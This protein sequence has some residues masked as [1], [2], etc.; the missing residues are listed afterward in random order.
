MSVLKHVT[1]EGLWDERRVETDF[2]PKV[3][4]L[5]GSNGSGKTTLLNLVASALSSD[6]DGLSRGHFSTIECDLVS[7]KS[8]AQTKVVVGRANKELIRPAFQYTIQGPGKKE[9]K[10]EIVS[11]SPRYLMGSPIRL[12]GRVSTKVYDAET[13]PLTEYVRVKWLTVHRAPTKARGEDRPTSD[14]SVDRHLGTLSNQL[15]RYFSKLAAQREEETNRFLREMLAS[16]IYNA[17]EFNPFTHAQGLDLATM[18]SS[19]E[20]LLDTFLRP[21]AAK[22]AR[23]RLKAHF[24]LAAEAQGNKEQ[25]K[26][27]ELIALATV[28]PMQKIVEEWGNTQKKQAALA[29]PRTEFLEIINEMYHNKQLLL[30][31]ENVLEVELPSG[32]HLTLLELSSGEKQLLILFAEALLQE[33]E[34]FIYMAD[35]PELSLHVTWQEQ[36]TRN[37][38]KANPNAQVIFATH[39]PDIVSQYGK[40]TIDMETLIA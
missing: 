3:N 23:E 16:L 11:P 5:I 25:F 40:N 9:L 4:F 22:K 12:Q 19:V 15:V 38:L 2:D 13:S 8:N 24:Q 29:R 7:P 34:E 10:F 30:N 39:S 33:R 32:K 27:E 21:A 6:Y 1:I 18:Q 14:S 31:Q 20:A 36:L 17:S 37:L 28:F 35:E 26:L